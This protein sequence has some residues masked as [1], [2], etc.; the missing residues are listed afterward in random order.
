MCL[1]VELRN[2]PSHELF[3]F[4]NESR[5]QQ[6][7]P[8]NQISHGE[9]SQPPPINQPTRIP[10]RTLIGSEPSSGRGAPGRQPDGALDVED[11]IGEPDLHRGSGQANGS[12]DQIHRAFLLREDV[13]DAGADPRLLAVGSC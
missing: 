1:C 13:F 6:R 4:W 9:A 11:Q 7:G 8:L 12:N 3:V 2:Q 5:A 10:A